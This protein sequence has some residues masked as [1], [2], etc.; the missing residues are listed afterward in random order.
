MQLCVS[1]CSLEVYQYMSRLRMQDAGRVLA[2]QVHQ[3]CGNQQR[4]NSIGAVI[5]P[6]YSLLAVCVFAWR[7][8]ALAA[9]QL[10]K[11]FCMLYDLGQ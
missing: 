9:F 7:E 3:L 6:S 2:R 10:K 11:A 8:G 5:C 4:Y 1:V